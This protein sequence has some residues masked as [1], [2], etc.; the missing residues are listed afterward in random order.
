MNRC[1]GKSAEGKVPASLSQPWFDFQ[2]FS[3][4]G[5][6]SNP[7]PGTTGSKEVSVRREARRN[8]RFVRN[9]CSF[10]LLTTQKV[11]VLVLTVQYDVM[12]ASYFVGYKVS[13]LC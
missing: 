2:E 3:Q 12:I 4:L 5:L 10:V 6:L 8:L 11:I 13:A 1:Q 9:A 7:H